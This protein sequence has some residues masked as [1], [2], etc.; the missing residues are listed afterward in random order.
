MFISRNPFRISFFGGGTD[1]PEWYERHGGAVLASAI[2]RHCYITARYLPPFFEHK[3]RIV[4]SIIEEV[5]DVA[6]IKHP[7]VR[8]CLRFMD[9]HDGMEIHHDGDLPKQTGLGTSSAF[10]AGLLHVLHA[11]R[12]ER[13]TAMQLAK[14]AIHVERTLCGDRVGSQDQVTA[15]FGGLNCIR[16]RAGGEIIVDPVVMDAAR[17]KALQQ[18]CMLFFTGFS[19]I[20]SEIATEQLQNLPRKTSELRR[21]GEMVDEGLR[22][23]TSREDLSA[24]G[25]LLH[26]GWTLKRGLSTKISNPVLDDLYAAARSAGATGGKLTGAGGGGF[27]LFFVEPEKQ[28]A[29]REA[30][31]NCLHVPFAFETEGS[32][33]VVFQPNALESMECLP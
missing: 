22:I 4:Y 3:H 13:P 17:R 23:L 10:T 1:Y 24:F 19:R 28:A 7:A 30:L 16:F 29:V 8:E 5:R 21:I 9:I 11:M 33:I 15:A 18:R 32:H 25:A 6:S 12:N 2:S 31:R 26:E 14:E 20:A 27:F